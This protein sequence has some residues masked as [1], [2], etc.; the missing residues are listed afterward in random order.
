MLAWL[1]IGWSV[2]RWWQERTSRDERRDHTVARVVLVLFAAGLVVVTGVNTVD[3]ARA[4]NP[5][6]GGSAWVDGLTRKV[7]EELPPGDGI[8]EIRAIGGAG[9]VWVGTGI[10]DQ[11]EHDGI[12]TRVA[13]DLGFAYG[14]DRVVDGEHVRL[15]VLPVQDPDLAA[16]RKL[17][18]L[19]EVGRVGKYTL[20]VQKP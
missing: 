4:G 20:F 14:P 11:L 17:P 2:L 13:P 18:G 1:A 8:V 12:E 19:E 16:A 15:V 7:R 9:S 3:A 10:A 6:P 5:D